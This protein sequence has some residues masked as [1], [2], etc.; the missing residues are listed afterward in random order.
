MKNAPI[1]PK[2]SIAILTKYL[3]IRKSTSSFCTILHLALSPLVKI[4]KKI[5]A[6]ADE[7]E[8]YSP[9]ED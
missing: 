4:Q 1:S 6:D 2:I 9:S 3:W 5:D 8:R 7:K